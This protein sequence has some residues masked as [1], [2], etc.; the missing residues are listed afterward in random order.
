MSAI[1][2]ETMPQEVSQPDEIPFRFQLSFRPFIDFLRKQ[3]QSCPTNNR[4]GELY[5]HMIDQFAPTLAAPSLETSYDA[6]QLATLFQMATVTVLPLVQAHQAISY[7]F[8]LP[9]PLTLFH[10]SAELDRL[11]GQFPTLL[12]DISEQIKPEDQQRFLYRL[13]LDKCYGVP[14]AKTGVS[15]FPFLESF[16]GLTSY[17][18]IDINTTFLEPI[19]HHSRTKTGLPEL[20][21]AWIDFANGNR[22]QP[23]ADE[24]LPLHDFLV[25]G[26]AFF[27]IENVTEAETVRQLQDVFA[28]LHSDS[29][30]IIYQRFET[31]LRNLCGQ[32]DLQISIVPFQQ[33]NGYFVHQPEISA[34]S[35]I[36]RHTEQV[37]DGYKDRAMQELLQQLIRQPYPR[38]FPALNGLPETERKILYRKGI[39]SF[40]WYPIVTGNDALGIL[41]MAS[42]QP[43]VLDERLLLKIE[44]VIPLIQELLRYQLNQFQQRMEQLIKAKFTSL[45]P[46]VEWKFREAAWEYLRLGSR[47]SFDTSGTQ[48][49]FPQVFPLYGAVDI[50]NS[51]QERHKAVCRDFSDQLAAAHQLLRQATAVEKT[52]QPGQLLTALDQWQNRQTSELSAED[53]LAVSSF[54]RQEIN[55]YFHQLARRDSGLALSI[56][57]YFQRTDAA[58]GQF[59]QALLD[60][61]RSVEWLNTAVNSFI[62]EQETKSIQSIYPH[63]FERYRTDGM[64]YT[65]YAGQSIAP[66][67]P[68]TPDLLRRFY[69]WQLNSMVEMAELTRLLLPSLPL[70]LQTTQLILAHTQPVNISFRQDEHRFDVEGSYS[71]RYEVLKKRIDKA[72]IAGTQER[73]TQPD[74]IALVYANPGELADYLPFIRTL[75]QQKKL[76]TDLDYVDLEPLQGVTVLKALRLHLAYPVSS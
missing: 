6:H 20:K 53:E 22:P 56:Q 54:L 26:F 25:E 5:Q 12:T 52:A 64:E 72:L 71:I 49:R 69:E 19:H 2:S 57:H 38:L 34:R 36:L 66:E 58:T 60:Y 9:L 1:R 61:E 63:Y 75:Q 47:D 41:E 45:Q 16:N 31:A 23:E 30:P 29:E 15:S 18:R 27:V 42:P 37:I 21:T 11:K 28:H 17:Y 76:K 3:Q 10:S 8:G 62:T 43:D 51:S 73:L 40:L 50:R 39:R 44:Q 7:G 70:P 67:K 68:F 24:A 59:H 65:L 35:V 4:L 13:V 32:P 46:A 55:P 48:V 74:T 14:L 33:V